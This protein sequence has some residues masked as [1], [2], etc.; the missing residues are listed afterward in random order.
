MLRLAS[1][2]KL[3][4]RANFSRDLGIFKVTNVWEWGRNEWMPQRCQ[5][6]RMQVEPDSIT[7]GQVIFK[8]FF[9]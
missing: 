6:S 2:F 4:T 3:P 7:Y 5:Q 1:V 8:K 9:S